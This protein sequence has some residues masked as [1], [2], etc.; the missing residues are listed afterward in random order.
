V[1]PLV[2]YLALY[3]P[4]LERAEAFYT[5]AFAMEILFRESE[6]DGEWWTL[7][8]EKGWSEARAAG[9]EVHMVALRRDDLVL[10]LFTGAPARGS[11]HEI[12]LGL[13]VD[14]VDRLGLNVDEAVTVPERSPGFVRFDDPFGF[15][16]V[17]QD[18]GASFR[19][20]GD[21]A[22]RWLDV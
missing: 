3:V 22:G 8:A 16:W 20:S 15:R 4:D 2:K 17:L 1:P 12:C 6:R 11:V 7:P 19:S 21:I 18:P 13:A 9:V 10:A 5:R 14:E